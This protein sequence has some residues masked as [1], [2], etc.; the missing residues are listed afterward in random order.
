MSSL[1]VSVDAALSAHSFK[2][3]MYTLLGLAGVFVVAWIVDRPLRERTGAGYAS[4]GQL[5]SIGIFAAAVNFVFRLGAPQYLGLG[6]VLAVAT[7]AAISFALHRRVHRTSVL[8]VGLTA[9]AA[10]ATAAY[11]VSWELVIW[12]VGL[13][14]AIGVL[15]FDTSIP[16]VTRKER[17]ILEGRHGEAF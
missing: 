5:L 8:A 14:F 9:Q 12:A 7:P 2:V 1:I 11:M 4:A 17:A 3:F 10:L 13:W 15:N 6:L 16:R